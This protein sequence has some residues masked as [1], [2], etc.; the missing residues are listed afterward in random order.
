LSEANLC[1]A[2][3]KNADLREVNFAKVIYNHATH[4]P[5]GFDPPE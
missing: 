3:L 1:T 2:N 5:D 4:W